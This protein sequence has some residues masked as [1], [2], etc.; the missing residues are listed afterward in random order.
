MTSIPLTDL[1][2][3]FHQLLDA[4]L[5]GMI[6]LSVLEADRVQHQMAVDMLT[7]DMSCDYNFILSEG[8][9][10]ELYCN[11]VSKFRLDIVSAR[12]ALHQM[13]VQTTVI[14]MVQVL[15]RGHFVECSFG[16]TVDSCH[17]PLVL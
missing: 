6:L 5:V 8:F 17:E 13:I 4:L 3:E 9:I 1:I 7:V 15:S 2:V 10:R 14:F 16:S 12:K 11:L